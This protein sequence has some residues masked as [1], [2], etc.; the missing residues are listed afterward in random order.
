[1][2]K[3]YLEKHSSIIIIISFISALVSLYYC[4]RPVPSVKV[5]YF[6]TDEIF[7]GLSQDNKLISCTIQTSTA[8]APQLLKIKIVNTLPGNASIKRI[9]ISSIDNPISVAIKTYYSENT[10][11]NVS[12]SIDSI[13]RQILLTNLP[14]LQPNTEIKLF[15][16]GELLDTPFTNI[17][18][19][20]DNKVSYL[21]TGVVSGFDLWISKNYWWFPLVI[22]VL[23]IRLLINKYNRSKINNVS[24]HNN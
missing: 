24:E 21:H 15:V 22:L 6:I 8:I 4:F 20:S 23:I 18:I 14:V 9:L 13:N 2:I 19:D 17:K 7:N 11:F 16:V 3:E 1:M 12:L 10:V 5:S